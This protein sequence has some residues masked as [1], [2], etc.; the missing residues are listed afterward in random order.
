[1]APTHFDEPANRAEFIEALAEA[2]TLSPAAVDILSVSLARRR[3]LLQQQSSLVSYIAMVPTPD[4]A[5][6]VSGRMA[7]SS[8]LLGALRSRTAVTAVTLVS[9]PVTALVPVAPPGL[10]PPVISS[11]SVTPSASLVNPGNTVS[12]EA[13]VVSVSA[14]TLTLRWS[15]LS[16]PALRLTAVNATLLTSNVLS[17]K[18][19]ALASGSTYV[20]HL[21]AA[22]AGGRATARALVTTLALPVPTLPGN[23]SLTAS[24]GGGNI[25][26]L[27]TLLNLSTSAALWN[28]A[29]LNATCAANCLALQFAFAYT[30]EGDA[31]RR[32]L[33]DFADSP[34]LTGVL[35]PPGSLTLQVYAR[36]ALGGV[37]VVPATLDVTALNVTLSDTLVE[38]LLP[39]NAAD[40]L[41]VALVTARVFA[42]AA[43][44]SDPEAAA[45]MLGNSTEAADTRGYLMSVLN[46]VATSDTAPLAAQ[47]PAA[48]ENLAAAVAS[49]VVV[50]E[51]VNAAC[52]EAA[53]GVLTRVSELSSLTPT[54]VGAVGDAL[55]A[56]VDA[57]FA[58]LGGGGQLNGSASSVLQ[59]QQQVAN[60]SGVLTNSLLSQLADSSVPPGGAA[61]T[62]SSP[63][64]QLYVALDLP[65]PGAANR[66]FSEPLT[67]PGS[68]S[69]FALP[70]DMFGGALEPMRTAF[71]SFTFDPNE[72]D[73]NNS[74]TG[75]TRLAF[76]NAAGDEL[77]ITNRSTPIY[78][79]LPPVP[80]LADGTK[81]QC[82][83]WD[84]AASNYST[85]GCISLPA[86]LPPGHTVAFVQ[87]FKSATDAGM[88]VAWN[89]SGPLV[90]AS[91]CTED[92]LDCAS[93]ADA[94]RKIYPNPAQPFAFPAVQC[95][96]NVSTSPMRVWS[97]KRCA[98]IQPTNELQCWW[99]NLKQAFTGP[100]CVASAGTTRCAC[101]HVR[102]QQLACIAHAA[103]ATD[104]A[105]ALANNS[106]LTDFSGKRKMSLP[107]AS[108][109]DMVSLNPAD[110]VTKLKARLACRW[111][112][113]LGRASDTL[114]R[115]A[116]PLHRRDCALLRHERRRCGWRC[117]GCARPP[118]GRAQAA[119][120]GGRLP[121]DGGRR[122][123]V[124]VPF[125]A[126][127]GRHRRTFWQRCAADGHPGDAV[128]SPASGAAR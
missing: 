15:Q 76:S 45:E 125:G 100:G 111:C 36:N 119:A 84:H 35:L 77:N 95:N 32:W 104:T 6:R 92:V 85:A 54:S 79:A 19:N 9:A 80:G 5:T 2:F 71:A 51:Q 75:M 7:D 26:A 121:A 110:L 60:V 17:L 116:V 22:D 97:G 122:V 37:S 44:L 14:A 18:P 83:W 91:N 117:A 94:D 16:G 25:T 81:A 78:F 108:L 42:V 59:L 74:G 126:A 103:L 65:T 61:L 64:I 24:W 31:G 89:I 107:M 105:A 11:I 106:Q 50:A 29:N 69:S 82:Q 66:L 70:S 63:A 47:T 12:L 98:L 113:S 53:I 8:N 101:R 99:D 43:I 62:M 27:T 57:S 10:V 58:A 55:S 56:L 86:L 72:L 114:P 20:F 30:L 115:A 120:A 1:L 48:V 102:A 112:A 40:S 96:A 127:C 23:G 13:N 87:N 4:E 41:P 90:S 52:A 123:G 28:D 49:L 3:S 21:E 33:S 73:M 67:A 38:S 68:N 128:R 118:Q 34:T 39:R 46:T 88:V 93:A 124:A 109:S